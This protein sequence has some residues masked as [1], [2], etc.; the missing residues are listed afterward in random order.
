MCAGQGTRMKSSLPKVL[1]P[2]AG[3]P[4]ILN[5]IGA[6][7]NSGVQEIRAI[8]G[9]GEA[10]VRRVL[11]PLGVTCLKQQ[12]QLGTADAV[13]A[14]D[15][16]TIEGD[17]IIVSGDTPLITAEQ[18]KSLY[19]EFRLSKAGLGV[20]YATVENP[21]S[22]GRVVRHYE[23]LKAI[24]EV[25]EA[26]QETLKIKD[27]NAGM[28]FCQSSILQEFLPKIKNN[29]NKKE[30]YLTDLVEI[31]QAHDE[32]V[33][34]L[35]GSKNVAFG[36]NTQKE[37][38]AA[39]KFVFQKKVENLLD[40][41]VIFID[42]NTVYI[43]LEAEVAAGAVIYPNVFI[44]GNSKIGNFSVIESNV[45]INNSQIGQG[46]QVRAGSY[47]EQ[48][49]IGNNSS[50]GPYARLRPE[51][52]IG[53]NCLIGNFV[54]V[55][56]TK[57][58]NRSKAAHL[59]YLGDA[60]IGEDVNVG[61]GTI[62][63]NYAADKKKYKTTIGDRV[64]VGSDTQFVAPVNIGADSIIGSGSTITKDVPAGAL[65]VARGK[66]FVKENYAAQLKKSMDAK[67]EN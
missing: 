37:L 5:V 44:R 58:G 67:K 34:A 19:E 29:N 9:H 41:G 47:L 23:Q 3:T 33:V 10:L 57:I 28:Y 21:G 43:E 30:F 39:T 36:V 66:Q 55:K 27:V 56:K 4:M 53:E 54:E 35:E 61:C 65:A 40:N 45:F 62:T 59:T 7:K 2:V 1:H 17:I 50:V 48:V 6:L 8:V 42:P 14:A 51:T 22:L 52:V 60:E 20:V 49:T 24:V 25:T 46:V 18:I 38:A 11:E 15:P 63:C 26:S 64:F 31:C 13:K 32:K 12:Q 16:S